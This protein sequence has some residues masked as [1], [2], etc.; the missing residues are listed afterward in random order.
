MGRRCYVDESFTTS[1]M[2]SVLLLPPGCSASTDLLC[3]VS[4]TDMANAQ[5]R[6][7]ELTIQPAVT[8]TTLAAVLKVEDSGRQ[9]VL[10]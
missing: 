10:H 4:D 5:Q 9:V 1:E 8:T 3:R 2:G 6:K 7:Q